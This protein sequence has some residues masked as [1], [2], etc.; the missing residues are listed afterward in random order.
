MSFDFKKEYKGFYLPKAKPEIVVV[1]RANYIAVRGQGDPNE[2][3]GAYQRAIGVLYAVAYTLKMSKRAGHE[4]D[5]FF[6]YVVPP[7][8]GFWQ[9]PDAAAGDGARKSDFRWISVLRLP[10]FITKTLTGALPYFDRKIP[11]FA[12]AGAV[13]TGVE[14]RSSAP[15]RIRRDRETFVAEAT[16][17]LYPMGEGAGYAGGIM[18]AAVDG[19]KAALAFLH[20]NVQY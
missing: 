4:I 20:Q 14:T 9:A 3:G 11:G 19:M 13:M 6:D 15:C 17:G 10:D 18:S 2:E 5:S 1:P 12:D 8:E 16:P 7:L